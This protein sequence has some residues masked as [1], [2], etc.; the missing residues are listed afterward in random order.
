MGNPDITHNLKVAEPGFL[1]FIKNM[2]ADLA[3]WIQYVGVKQDGGNLVFQF[4]SSQNSL[5]F[6]VYAGVNIT[7][8]FYS[9][10]GQ[11]N[12]IYEHFKTL[13]YSNLK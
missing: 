3:R 11:S 10:R 2:S 9:L 12:E 8:V 4:K 13:K 5:R 1:F 6:E 7:H